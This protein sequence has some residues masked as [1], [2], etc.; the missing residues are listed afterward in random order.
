MAERA[1][2]YQ[3][4]LPGSEASPTP[5]PKAPLEHRARQRANDL[6]GKTW[7]RYSISIWSD[8][9]KTQ[10]EID[11]GHPA[12]FPVALVTRLIQCFTTQED[13]VVLDPFAGV[14]STVLAAEAMGKAGIGL[15][16]SHEYVEK[17]R[18]R[19]A[20]RSL[21]D[22]P[23][24]LPKGERTLYCADANDL[25]SYVAPA[26]VDLV[27]TSPPYWDILLQERTADYK[28]IRHYGE[29]PRDLGRIRDY[30]QFLQALKNIFSHVY[31]ALKP[32]KFCCVI[33]MDLRKKN[34]FYPFHMDVSQFMQE[35]GFILD[36]IIIWDRRHEYNNMRPLGYPS[37]FRINKAHEYILVFQKPKAP[38]SSDE[39]LP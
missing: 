11:L 31:K 34:R 13:R 15:E 17:A 26:S 38:R 28:A 18:R 5:A 39:R 6:D 27:V 24:D 25:L 33:V 19:P 10:E 36:D 14:G 9:R 35:I 8:I 23:P 32:G 12:L 20:V 16:I 2:A 7:T 29:D 3:I 37:R 4:A 1:T 30:K 22:L 21:L